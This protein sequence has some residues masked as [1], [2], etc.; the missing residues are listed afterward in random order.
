MMSL[1]TKEEVN[2]FG[3]WLDIKKPQQESNVNEG[4]MS[5]RLRKQYTKLLHKIT[6]YIQIVL[7]TEHRQKWEAKNV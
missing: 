5:L 4:E 2:K 3:S 1:G 6:T 7:Q